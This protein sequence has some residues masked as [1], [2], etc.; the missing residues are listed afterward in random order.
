MPTTEIGGNKIYYEVGGEGPPL[1]LV[2]G[3]GTPGLGWA[4]QVPAL[5][6]RY[7]TIS[8]DNRGCGRS[9]CPPGPYAVNELAA[10]ALGLLD[11]L[12]VPRAHLAGISMG[13]MIAQEI[14]VE[15]PERVAALVL[16]STY[17]APG[18]AIWRLMERGREL[19]G[20][21][22]DAFA[23][24]RFL[25]DVAFTPSFIEKDGIRIMQLLAEAMPDGP[26]L[27]GLAAQ[28][29][30]TLAFDARPRLPSVRAPTLVLTGDA[31]KLIP[32]EHSDEIAALVPGA[33]LVRIAGG[34]HAVNFEKPEEWNRIVLAFLA[35][36]DRLLG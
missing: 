4:S 20:A 16:A 1:L 31:D 11:A 30:A 9:A 21:R 27:A 23:A 28:S 14:A 17:A 32:A 10:D 2:M 22:A 8:F 18:P 29:A 35:E 3:L 34:S 12:D 7:R 19:M 15:H 26:N 33:R 5:R 24:L 6:T 36:H 13:G 25:T